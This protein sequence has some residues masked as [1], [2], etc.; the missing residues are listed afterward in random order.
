MKALFVLILL[1]PL[2]LFAQTEPDST[3]EKPAL[4]EVQI[5]AIR[6][7]VQQESDRIILQIDGSNALGNTASQILEQAPGVRISDQSIEL[8]G[9]SA[10]IWVNGRPTRLNSRQLMNMLQTQSAKS[11]D[12]IELIPDAGAMVAADG[13]GRIINIQLRRLYSYDYLLDLS[14]QTTQRSTIPATQNSLDYYQQLNRWNLNLSLFHYI[15]T[16]QEI[17]DIQR[18]FADGLSLLENSQHRY[19]YRGPE[20]QLALEYQPNERSTLGVLY[21]HSLDQT[22]GTLD[23]LT[24]FWQANQ[25]D[26]SVILTGT[27]RAS[28]QHQ[29]LNL[30]YDRA[31]DSL[32][33][34]LR[35]NFDI[36]QKV[37]EEGDEQSITYPLRG[38]EPSFREQDLR[39]QGQVI[40]GNLAYQK[41][42]TKL[43]LQ[44]GIQYTQ[45][46][47]KQS[48]LQR[49][50]DFGSSNRLIYDEQIAATW[51]SMQ[52]SYWGWNWKMG[53]R[54]EQTFYTGNTLDN[55]PIDSS[56]FNLFPN[57]QLSRKIG[58][59]HFLSL[60]VRRSI[61]RPRFHQLLPS[62]RYVSPF[63]Y[64]QGNP[65]LLAYFPYRAELSY[66]FKSRLYARVSYSEADKRILEYS[67]TLSNDLIT[68]GRINNNG[69]AQGLS[70]SIGYN[71]PITPWWRLNSNIAYV[72]GQQSFDFQQQRE[73]IQYQAATIYLANQFQLPHDF[74]FRLSF[75]G[76][77]P[78][79]YQLDENQAF[80]YLDFRISRDF[81]EDRL[82]IS[83]SGR[84]IFKMGVTR[85]QSQY[86]N[87]D[88]FT[89]HDW[90]SRQWIFNIA[91]Q[92][93]SDDAESRHGGRTTANAG[94][95]SRL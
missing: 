29:R 11:I 88:Y 49:F 81:L 45:S 18:N 13:N 12:K 55:N 7:R 22:T 72:V 64:Y 8:E 9:Q 21:S 15:D 65:G 39:A 40:G 89:R 4:E 80:G 54:A 33:S 34:Y 27:E 60:S 2:S 16:R 56:Y 24:D 95:R 74:G 28:E 38:T 26:S 53:L 48:F 91:Y 68:E 14:N 58:K 17:S 23:G 32:G 41:V 85:Q 61:R 59:D 84:D 73:Q 37:S 67:Q 31:L 86:G 92:F 19:Q 47:I 94:V 90:D 76:S 1:L 35:F 25:I 78:I 83:F 71:G 57:L 30:F 42:W 20:A 79:Y 43:R 87:V 70:A 36:D 63:Y 51:L 46:S 75:Y 66:R 6:E 10:E 62:K 82:Q 69:Q 50:P 52:T 5:S 77:S 44:S 3:L 93:G